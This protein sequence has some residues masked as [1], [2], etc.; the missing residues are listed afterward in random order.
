[1]TNK[2]SH[3]RGNGKNQPV[4][5]YS[6]VNNSIADKKDIIPD[7]YDI[8]REIPPNQEHYSKYYIYT[9]YK[10]PFWHEDAQKSTRGAINN[11]HS[12]H[13]E[14]PEEIKSEHKLIYQEM[15]E[16]VGHLP[17]VKVFVD[18]ILIFSE[19][20]L[21][22]MDHSNQVLNHLNM[23]G[24]E[25]RTEKDSC[26]LKRMACY[27]NHVITK[28]GVQANTTI[29]QAL[30]KAPPPEKCIDVLQFIY[31]CK[32]IL[33]YIP[34]FNIII[35]PIAEKI[36][37]MGCNDD[38]KNQ[39]ITWTKEDE[40]ARQ[41]I[42]YQ[43]ERQIAFTNP[44]STLPFNLYTVV[45]DQGIESILTQGNK[46]IGIFST[47][48]TA[49]ELDKKLTKTEK[50]AIGIIG[51]VIYFKSLISKENRKMYICT[52]DKDILV[53]D[54]TTNIYVRKMKDITIH[55]NMK[56]KKVTG[57]E[58]IMEDYITKA[59]NRIAHLY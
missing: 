47:L 4:A 28:K 13:L 27:G 33:V 8:L 36:K 21:E 41:A 38:N 25:L 39:P 26:V 30:K 52:E 37:K 14:T 59:E 29:F 3:L 23:L 19:T 10:Q 31:L 34:G 17:F 18:S 43:I 53:C 54:K 6:K 42:I 11:Q 49:M 5:D 35:A 9:S 16:V 45:R 40:K 12:A 57:Q 32:A 51:A 48:F 15:V 50:E 44:V 2:S 1:M 46:L 24:L 58:S 55:Y 7:I 20:L 56:M 22:H